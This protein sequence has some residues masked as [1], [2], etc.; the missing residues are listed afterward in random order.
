[1]INSVTARQGL[2]TILSTGTKISVW[3]ATSEENETAWC[4][5]LTG[6]DGSEMDFGLS[7]EAFQ[8]FV[9]LVVKLYGKES[10][11]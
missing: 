7:H 9:G 2:S 11:A 4:C 10:L 5:K 8:A 1:M 3:P 6:L